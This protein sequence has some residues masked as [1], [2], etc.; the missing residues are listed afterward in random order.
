MEQAQRTAD[1]VR[2]TAVPSLQ[3][4]ARRA[5]ELWYGTALPAL[6]S[7]YLWISETGMPS[8]FNGCKEA[9]RFVEDTAVPATVA[10]ANATGDFVREK[11]VP[12]FRD[13]CAPSPSTPAHALART[14]ARASSRIPFAESTR[15]LDSQ[16]TYAR[17]R[18]D[19]HRF[20]TEEA[21]PA[22]RDAFTY[23]RDSAIPAAQG[24]ATHFREEVLPAA[25]DGLK[26]AAET[27]EAVKP[28]AVEAFHF[29]KDNY[30]VRRGPPLCAPP[31]LRQG[32]ALPLSYR[33][34][35]SLWCVRSRRRLLRAES[36][37]AFWPAASRTDAV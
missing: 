17:S 35:A 20:V 10:A 4:H 6:E 21:A 14:P 33:Q 3:E 25:K 32:P 31:G 9:H 11:A 13:G 24:A 22:A 19:R 26:Q 29:V 27:F 5:G 30:E 7:A 2:A 16:L 23:F 15:L 18:H 36:A 34:W 37:S 1:Y 12:A 28:H 8:L